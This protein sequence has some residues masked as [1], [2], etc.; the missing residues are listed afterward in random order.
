MKTSFDSILL[1]LIGL[2]GIIAGI[3]NK[4]FYLGF[5]WSGGF[6]SK[7]HPA[8]YKYYYGCNC[9]VYRIGFVKKT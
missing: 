8:L 3:I 9:F 5:W 1:I 7:K 4:G 6:P 2:W